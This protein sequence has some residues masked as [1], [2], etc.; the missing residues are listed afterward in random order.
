MGKRPDILTRASG[1]GLKTAERVILE[2]QSR[3][4]MPAGKTNE[5]ITERMDVNREAEDALVG[6]GYS[7]VEVRRITSE[8]GPNSKPW[9]IGFAR[10]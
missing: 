4:K 8:V 3:I 7:R 2:L 5:K 6:L 1:V 10:P 9:K